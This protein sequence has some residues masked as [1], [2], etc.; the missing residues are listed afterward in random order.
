[1]DVRV[2]SI[3]PLAPVDPEHLAERL[4]LTAAAVGNVVLA[5]IALILA[6]LTVI[7]WPLILV[8]VGLVTLHLSVRGTRWLTAVPRAASGAVLGERIAP[9]WGDDSG[10]TLLNRPAVWAR[11]PATWRDFGWLLFAASG[12]FVLSL[13]PP[14]MLAHA[15]VWPL[16]LAINPSRGV[17]MVVG[18]ISI[19]LLLAWW[20]STPFLVRTRAIADRA[21][22]R[23]SREAQLERRVETVEA[24][25][26][27][28]VDHSAAELRRLERDL[29]DGAQARIVSAGMSLGLAEQMV[30]SDPEAA[31]ALLREARATTV[32]ALDDL[33]TVL[34]GIQPP[35]LAD[36]GLVGGVEALVADVPLPVTVSASGVPRLPAPIE[37]AAYFAIA[38]C[39]TNAVKHGDA[40]RVWVG[41]QHE[42]GRLRMECGDDGEG[43]A[44]ATGSGLA[45]VARRLSAFDG[46]MA[47]TSP[48]G[49]PTIVT[50]EVPCQPSSPPDD[51]SSSPKT[52]PS[53]GKG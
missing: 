40:T 25:R 23:P 47:V 32:G 21:I 27:D 48:P 34:R 26:T 20:L 43:G 19:P 8:A 46:T 37:S 24:S 1:M 29:H 38:E 28:V 31:S 11:D 14:L 35:A 30:T 49:G 50:M 15:I 44:D 10:C 39:V 16:V 4:R 17:A 6:A 22:L 42:G 7:S 12:G 53:S 9:W 52:S 2:T 13:L 45:G 18:L 36:R 5:P 33:R 51:G 41:V 3:D